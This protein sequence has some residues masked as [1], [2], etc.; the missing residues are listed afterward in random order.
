[1]HFLNVDEETNVP[2]EPEPELDILP[3]LLEFDLIDCGRKPNEGELDRAQKRI[4]DVKANP[5]QRPGFTKIKPSE[6][7]SGE[8]DEE[9]L[10][11]HIAE[12]DPKENW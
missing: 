5:K 11:N 6:E 8:I 10:E 1:M 7:K 3:D 12:N 9:D 4:K 2:C